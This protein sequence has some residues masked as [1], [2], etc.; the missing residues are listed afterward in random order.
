[1]QFGDAKQQQRT[2][3]Q[4][5]CLVQSSK[6]KS[7]FMTSIINSW[8]T[9]PFGLCQLYEN[10]NTCFQSVV[11][12]CCTNLSSNHCLISIFICS[13]VQNFRLIM[14]LVLSGNYAAIIQSGIR[15]MHLL[16]VLRNC[17]CRNE[18]SCN[19]CK[20][21]TVKNNFYRSVELKR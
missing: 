18:N 21:R 9:K 1:M 5:Y 12:K 16:I 19:S 2:S 10:S 3:W 8:S 6:F 15:Q 7:K 14:R 4:W 17:V 20:M 11:L 13:T